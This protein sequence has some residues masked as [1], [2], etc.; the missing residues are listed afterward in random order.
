[1]IF[2][3]NCS[4]LLIVEAVCMPKEKKVGFVPPEIFSLFVKYYF[5]PT[6][7]ELYPKFLE[8]KKTSCFND[9]PMCLW[10]ANILAKNCGQKNSVNIIS[11]VFFML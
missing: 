3:P 7:A 6:F 10:S 2:N 5:A 11:H 1:M 8:E 4:N 9:P